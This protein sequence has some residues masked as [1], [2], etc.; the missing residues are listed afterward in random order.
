MTNQHRPLAEVEKYGE[1]HGVRIWPWLAMQ[2]HYGGGY[3]G[4]FRSA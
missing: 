4:I 2:R 1:H 3:G